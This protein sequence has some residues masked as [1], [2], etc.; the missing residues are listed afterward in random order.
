MDANQVQAII[1]SAVGEAQQEQRSQTQPNAM[2]ARVNSLCIETQ[3]V[4]PYQKISVN[5]QISCNIPWDII[6]SVPEFIGGS[7]E[8]VA[9]ISRRCLRAV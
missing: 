8:Y 9:W 3:Q 7:D 6:K 5:P 2:S 4:E 1:E